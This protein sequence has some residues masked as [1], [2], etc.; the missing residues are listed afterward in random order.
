MAKSKDQS[1]K[2]YEFKITL[3]HVESHSK[4][5]FQTDENGVMFIP[6]GTYFYSNPLM[7]FELCMDLS[8]RKPDKHGIIIRSKPGTSV[9]LDSGPTELERVAAIIRT[10]LGAH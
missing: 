7:L 9:E 5:T 2:P 6:K 3:F 8:I 1:P 10:A 4:V